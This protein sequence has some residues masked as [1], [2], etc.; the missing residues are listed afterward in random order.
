[1]AIIYKRQRTTYLKALARADK[2]DPGPLGEIWARAILENLT[3]FVMPAVAGDVK[4]LPLEALATKD[5]SAV[6]L[7]AAARRGGLVARCRADVVP[8]GSRRRIRTSSTRALARWQRRASRDDRG[9][10][11][12]RGR[13]QPVRDLPAEHRAAVLAL[14]VSAGRAALV[15]H[16]ADALRRHH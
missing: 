14:R 4:L 13:R 8:R 12:R 5:L 6:A 9:D 10:R 2:G 3:R 15:R 16:P 11:H 1:P 7:R